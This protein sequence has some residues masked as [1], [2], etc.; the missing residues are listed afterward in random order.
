[1][2][3]NIQSLYT[4]KVGNRKIDRIIVALLIFGFAFWTVYNAINTAVIY[5]NSVEVLGK[6]VAV[7][8][9]GIYRVEHVSNNQK[10]TG[11]HIDRSYLYMKGRNQGPIYNVGNLIT[12]RHIKGYDQVYT[13][14]SLLFQIFN[15]LI[16]SFLLLAI[17]VILK[18]YRI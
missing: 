2:F 4:I 3:M 18:M 8:N 10:M 14:S 5:K 13:S 17:W 11:Y 9:R 6:I 1:M 16:F 15:P 12:I 7:E